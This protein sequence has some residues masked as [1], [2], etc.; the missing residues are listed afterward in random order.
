MTRSQ[1]K[2]GRK[3]LETLHNTSKLDHAPDPTFQ[4]SQVCGHIR[5]I[6]QGGV[7]AGPARSRGGGGEKTGA[8]VLSTRP[9]RA[10]LLITVLANFFSFRVKCSRDGDSRFWDFLPCGRISGLILGVS[11]VLGLDLG[12]WKGDLV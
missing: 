12:F 10:L 6:S 4:T 9:P 3:P 2:V 1:G 7:A 5:G 11:D 8:R